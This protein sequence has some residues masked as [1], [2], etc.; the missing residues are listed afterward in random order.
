MLLCDPAAGKGLELCDGHT[1]IRAV[2][3]ELREAFLPGGVDF[4]TK[5]VLVDE[6]RAV[7]VTE[8][9]G[10]PRHPDTRNSLD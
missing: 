5:S 3:P 6:D 4:S 9:A 1:L 7:A 2:P 8:V 10:G